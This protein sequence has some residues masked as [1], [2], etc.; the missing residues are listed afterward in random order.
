LWSAPSILF[1]LAE[2]CFDPTRHIAGVLGTT[3][4]LG[5]AGATFGDSQNFVV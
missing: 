1:A 2:A 5:V 3:A 4:A